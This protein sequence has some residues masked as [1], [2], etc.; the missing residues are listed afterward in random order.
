M[1]EDEGEVQQL[2]LDRIKASRGGNRA[3]VT[4][5]EREGNSLIVD[6]A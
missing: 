3:V 4:R 2:T 1:L 5:L 6:H